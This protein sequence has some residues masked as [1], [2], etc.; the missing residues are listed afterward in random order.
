MIFYKIVYHHIIYMCDFLVNL[1]DFFVV[2]C[3]SFPRDT[4]P[5]IPS[6]IPYRS[7]HT[8]A[9]I[10]ACHSTPRAGCISSSVQDA[11]A[12]VGRVEPSV[13]DGPVGGVGEVDAIPDQVL[14]RVAAGAGPGHAAPRPVVVVV[15]ALAAGAAAHSQPVLQACAHVHTH[16]LIGSGHV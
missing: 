13:G 1:D 3:T 10:P 2:V 12:A 4:L 16:G 6:S 11:G 9:W 8:P 5:I 14:L 15:A 7:L